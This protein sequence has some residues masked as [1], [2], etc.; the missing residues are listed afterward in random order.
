MTGLSRDHVQWKAE[1]LAL[2]CIN[3]YGHVP[4]RIK[5]IISAAVPDLPGMLGEMCRDD[6]GLALHQAMK[7]LQTALSATKYNPDQPR[8]PAG[9]TGGGQWTSGGDD[10]DA[11]TR[12]TTL[13]MTRVGSVESHPA[14]VPIDASDN[15][16]LYPASQLTTSKQGV[17][18]IADHETFESQEYLDTA[19][20]PTIGFGHRILPNESFPNGITR[21][22]AEQ[23]LAQDIGTAEKAVQKS[24]KVDITQPQFDA[25]TSFTYNA[26]VHSL[27]TSA[28]LHLLNQGDYD[29]AANQFQFWN[30]DEVNGVLAVSAGLTNRR[31]A[32]RNLFVNGQYN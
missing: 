29:G 12:E 8:V 27:R 15:S 7:T 23:L 9:S 16:D 28:L 2:R 3:A 32:E 1:I 6:S 18:F 17:K 31:N 30:K 24:V 25:L 22:E 21:D 14:E 5:T 4:P 19:E 11:V 26:G 13:D 10:G 20:K